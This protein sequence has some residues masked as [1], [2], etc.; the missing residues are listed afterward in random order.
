MPDF[1]ALKL[2]NQLG[3][4]LYACAK[5]V[6][7]LYTQHLAPLDLTYTQYI[8]LAA[9]FEEETLSV[10]D[11]CARLY[12]D[13]GTMTPLLKKLEQRKLLV[14][15][16]D[17]V[18]ERRVHITITDAGKALKTQAAAVQEAVDNDIALSSTDA[19]LLYTLLYKTLNHLREMEG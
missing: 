8:T 10:K 3:F 15:K 13:T 12:L 9:L 7:R 18:D 19:Y 2:E 17:Y 5:E 11:L 6:V 14:R 1:E 4:P 16:R